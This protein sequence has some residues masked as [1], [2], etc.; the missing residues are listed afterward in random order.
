MTGFYTVTPRSKT[1]SLITV[2]CRTCKKE[3]IFEVF[4]DAL[5]DYQQGALIQRAFPEL[6]KATREL[7]ISNTCDECFKKMFPPESE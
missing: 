1:K 4:T 2:S 7:M 5:E 6:S 3:F